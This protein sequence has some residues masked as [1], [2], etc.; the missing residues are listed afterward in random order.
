MTFLPSKDRKYLTDHG[1]AYEEVES[2][3][4]KGV[5]LKKRPLP[6][7]KYDVEYADILIILPG[8]YPDTR[9]DMFHTLPWIRLNNSNKFPN[10]ADQEVQFNDQKWQRWSRHNDEWRSGIDGIWTMLKRVKE[11]LEIA[12]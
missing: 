5:I 7:G 3:G 1:I 2:G 11:A 8:N 6:T 9:P 12:K 10:A 4:Q